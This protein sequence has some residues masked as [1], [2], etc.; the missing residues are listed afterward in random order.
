MEKQTLSSLLNNKL[1]CIPDY[2]RGYAWEEKQ[3]NDFIQDV[4]ALIEGDIKSH[5]TGTIVTF[6]PPNKPFENYG[7]TDKLEKVDIVDGQQRLTTI[8]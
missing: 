6:Q 8:K 7:T 4:D 1:F 2:Q 3:W 5:Y